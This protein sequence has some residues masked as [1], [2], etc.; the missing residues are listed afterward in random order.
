M[1]TQ[2]TPPTIPPL[3]PSQRSRLRN[4]VMDQVNPQHSATRR[5][6]APVIAVGAVAAVVA[7]TIALTNGD[8]G[9]PGVTSTT[10]SST[11]SGIRS[12]TKAP[13][14][15]LEIPADADLGPVPATEAATVANKSCKLPN[16]PGVHVQVLWARRVRGLQGSG[17]LLLVKG[18]SQPGGYFHQGIATCLA[19][20]S[21]SAVRDSDWAKR[22]TPAQGMSVL[23]GSG[24]SEAAA[25]GKP[26]RT[27][28]W[29]LYRVRPEIVRIE[30]RLVWKNGSAP[31]IKG[32]VDNGYAYTDSRSISPKGLPTDLTV[33][34]RAYNTQGKEVPVKP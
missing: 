9:A 28:F 18:P 34:F 2:V 27:Q 25:G 33:Q 17:M 1:N 7:G 13:P 16:E 22:P 31:W 32:V 10:P 20:M 21:I 4:R 30:S 15:G 3:S 29:G 26:A 11:P 12:A 6:A 14:L 23:G 5:W 19:G 8:Q 24:F